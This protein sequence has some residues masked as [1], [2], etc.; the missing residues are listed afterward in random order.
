MFPEPPAMTRGSLIAVVGLMLLGPKIAGIVAHLSARRC[1]WRQLPGFTLSVLVEVALS[2][3]VAPALMVHQVRAVL[4]TL[5]GFD[6]GWMPHLSGP[7]SWRFLA[8]LHATETLLGLT[9]VALAAFGQLTPW[10][11]PVAVSLAL[12]IPVSWLVQQ[13]IGSNWLLRPLSESS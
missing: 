13:R 7:A 9:L 8:R 2:M 6:G 10:L 11:F 1:G 12:T 4:R 5:A 3:L